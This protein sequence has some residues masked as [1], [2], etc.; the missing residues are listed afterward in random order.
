MVVTVTSTAINSIWMLL[1]YIK[2]YGKIKIYI[3]YLFLKE[4]LKSSIPITFSNFFVTILNTL[5]ILILG[6]LRP[7]QEVG[8]FKAAFQILT[9]T[10]VP[11]IIIQNAFF[12]LISRS[13]TL[14]ERQKVMKKFFL[15]IFL[16]GSIV[17]VGF[18]TFSEYLTL[19][20]FGKYYSQTIDVMKI[21][22]ISS[23][24]IY[25]NVGT[26]VPLIG[27]KK[28]EV[29]NVLCNCRS[30]YQYNIK[31][32]VN[33]KVWCNWCRLQQGFLANYQ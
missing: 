29:C 27:W 13:N 11:T 10:T 20:V 31:F 22:M 8:Y 26:T 25:I 5:N 21:L 6:M 1:L 19:T 28:R 9:L 18:F 23:V 15:L 33:S 3:N 4:L 17:S 14:E 32:H 7:D 2:M 30:N 24:I 12:P 16:I